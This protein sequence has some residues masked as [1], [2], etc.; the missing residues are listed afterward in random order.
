MI[1]PPGTPGAATMTT[2]SIITKWRNVPKPCAVPF[3]R[4]I[5]SAH[6]VIFMAD[7]DRWIVAQSG[8]VKPASGQGAVT[9]EPAQHSVSAVAA[10][11]FV[12]DKDF[13]VSIRHYVDADASGAGDGSSWADAWPSL[14]SALA[15]VP[16]GSEVWVAEGTYKPTTGTDRNARFVLPSRAKL[17]GGFSGVETKRSERDWIKHRTVLSGEIGNQSSQTD[18]SPI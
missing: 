11:A 8:T 12:K 13:V 17:Y 9:A 15:A 16:S 10:G 5:V 4:Q 18:N 14:A 1:A 2:P 3:M 6:A 7:P